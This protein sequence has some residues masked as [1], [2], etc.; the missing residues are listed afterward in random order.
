MIAAAKVRPSCTIEVTRSSSSSVRNRGCERTSTGLHPNGRRNG[1]N[2]TSMT[3]TR[4][5]DFSRAKALTRHTSEPTSCESD[6][7][8]V[9]SPRPHDPHQREQH[10][11]TEPVSHAHRANAGRHPSRGKAAKRPGRLLCQRPRLVFGPAGACDACRACFA[12]A[13]D[14]LGIER[15]DGRR[16]DR[17][18]LKERREGNGHD[19]RRHQ[20]EQHQRPSQIGS[21]DVR[22]QS[23]M[24]QAIRNSTLAATAL[25][26]RT[27]RIWLTTGTV[28]SDDRISSGPP[29]ASPGVSSRCRFV[30]GTRSA[31]CKRRAVSEPSQSLSA[32]SW[33]CAVEAGLAQN[34]GAE[35]VSQ[36]RPVAKHERLGLESLEQL[37]DRGVVR[38]GA[39]GYS[40]VTRSRIVCG[41]K[42]HRASSTLSSALASFG[43][44]RRTFPLRKDPDK[45]TESQATTTCLTCQGESVKN[46]MGDEFPRE[47]G[48]AGVGRPAVQGGSNH[49]RELR[50]LFEVF[51]NDENVVHPLNCHRSTIGHRNG[52]F[53]ISLTNSSVPFVFPEK[54]GRPANAWQRNDG[55][56]RR[57]TLTLRG[58]V[59]KSEVAHATRMSGRKEP[60]WTSTALLGF[61][62]H[63][64]TTLGPA[65]MFACPRCG[66]PQTSG[67]SYELA[68][69]FLLL[70]VLPAFVMRSAYVICD[71]CGATLFSQLRLA[72][73]EQRCGSDISHF[74]SHHVSLVLKF[75][76]LVSLLLW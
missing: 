3:N 53:Y 38:R 49:P 64:Q 2:R 16:L 17:L 61:F 12:R 46:G 27:S 21:A 58:K 19:P 47:G 11:T 25:P 29:R 30:S 15:G 5:S 7:A 14:W 67:R 55:G 18:M 56:R 8:R 26:A 1:V 70:Y 41:P 51:D 45:V 32:I 39:P 43:R 22:V 10:D 65:V 57:L 23:V 54:L 34:G 9:S 6:A 28:L 40:R 36:S 60:R 42:L 75:L 59:D 35:H 66:E 72:D 44:Q 52:T 31:R 63:R 62:V 68:E 73:L 33:S 4:G 69:T 71:H 48:A 13:N 20:L 24:P 76:T 50:W 37:L 74:V